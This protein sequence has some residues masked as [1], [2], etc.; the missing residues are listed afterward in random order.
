MNNFELIWE[1]AVSIAFLQL[2]WFEKERK[3]KKTILL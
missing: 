2:L 3:K 1:S